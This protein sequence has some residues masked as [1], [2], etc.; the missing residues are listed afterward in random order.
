[1]TTTERSLGRELMSFRSYWSAEDGTLVCE[2]RRTGMDPPI[3]QMKN[4]FKLMSKVVP[5]V[6]REIEVVMTVRSVYE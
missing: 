5:D 3:E 4:L 6:G 2:G 1:M